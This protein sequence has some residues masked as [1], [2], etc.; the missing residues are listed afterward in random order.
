[1]V[2]SELFN[3]HY[4]IFHFKGIIYMI[5]QY[6]LQT[7]LPWLNISIIQLSLYCI[8]FCNINVNIGNIEKLEKNIN[9]VSSTNLDFFFDKLFKVNEHF[10]T[11][12]TQ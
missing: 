4:L 12:I 5:F 2:I 3:M 8:Y 9:L 11:I 1:M 6:C 7:L 10:I